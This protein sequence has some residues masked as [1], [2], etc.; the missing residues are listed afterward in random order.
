[1]VEHQS[2]APARE[3]TPRE[4]RWRAIRER[5]ARGMLTFNAGGVAH[6][7]GDLWAVRSATHGGFHRVDLAAEECTCPDYVHYGRDRGVACRHVYAVAIAHATRR[8][9]RVA[10]LAADIASEPCVR[11]G[12]VADM[13][14]LDGVALCEGCVLDA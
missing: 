7:E 9:R 3:G 2:S 6:L 8:S 14:T 12:A 4:D 10:I 13:E 1:V 11:C 5:T